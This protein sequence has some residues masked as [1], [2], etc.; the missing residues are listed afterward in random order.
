MPSFIGAQLYFDRVTQLSGIFGD[1]QTTAIFKVFAWAFQFL[2]FTVMLVLAGNVHN[3]VLRCTFAALLSAGAA[4]TLSYRLI[5]AEDLG[6]FSFTT[7]LDSRSAFADVIETYTRELMIAAV[8][9]VMIAVGIGLAPSVKR[10]WPQWLCAGGPLIGYIALSAL[11]FVRNGDGALA[12]PPSWAS[13]AYLPLYVSEQ[14]EG[15]AGA[16]QPVSI[17]RTGERPAADIVLIVD[18]SIAGNYLDINGPRGVRS[19]LL[20]PRS[21]VAVNNFGLAASIANC[22]IQSNVAL[23]FGGTRGDFQRIIASKPS[24][25]SYAKAAGMQTVMLYAQRKGAHENYMTEVERKGIDQMIWFEDIEAMQR[26]QAVAAKLTA[27]LNNG[28]AE[29]IYVNKLGAHFPLRGGYPASYGF[30]K[31]ALEATSGRIDWTD[32]ERSRRLLIGQHDDWSRYRNSYRNRLTWS[33]GAF[34]DTLLTGSNLGDATII[35]TSDHGQ[36]LH[37]RGNPGLTT[38]CQSQPE[39]EEGVVPLVVIRSSKAE[40]V[41]WQAAASAGRN[42]MSH[43]RIFP[44]LLSLM[45]YDEASVERTYGYSLTQPQR[46]PMTFGVGMHIKFRSRPK[47]IHIPVDKV[48]QPPVSD[49]AE[50]IGTAKPRPISV[51]APAN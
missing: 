19:G 32:N 43:Y 6:F 37:E 46:D 3:R 4:F 11:L 5:N 39:I 7:M 42:R 36:T 34:F 15:R 27:L 47:W 50:P 31:P 24:I 28:K 20:E 21:G 14:Q 23:R 8:G 13:L 38:H 49:F 2:F 48:I 9:A 12:L 41:D 30:Y 29:F 44:T 10:G 45:G 22:S 17:T 1:S 25:W 18:E 16:R 33:V 35:Y 26:D 40:D 51:N